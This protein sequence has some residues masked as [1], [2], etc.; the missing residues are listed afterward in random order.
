MKIESKMNKIYAGIIALMMLGIVFSSIM[1]TRTITD[2]GDTWTGTMMISGNTDFKSGSYYNL[3]KKIYNSKG[4]VY[5]AT[6]PNIQLAVND[7]NSTKGGTV[8][9]PSGTFTLTSPLRFWKYEIALEGSGAVGDYHMTNG[10]IITGSAGVTDSLV[11]LGENSTFRIEHICF[12]DGAQTGGGTRETRCLIYTYKCGDHNVIKECFF[13]GALSDAIHIN[14]SAG[15]GG[16]GTLID[17]CQFLNFGTCGIYLDSAAD[18][19][20]DH[21]DLCSTDKDC[22]FVYGSA[23]IMIRDCFTYLSRNGIVIDQ[24]GPSTGQITI[25]GCHSHDNTGAGFLFNSTSGVMTV[26]GCTSDLNKYG[27]Y[28]HGTSNDVSHITMTGC[29]SDANTVGLLMLNDYTSISSNNITIVGC[30]FADA[31]AT[32]A[33]DTGIRIADKAN[34]VTIK[35]CSFSDVTYKINVTTS[36]IRS[37]IELFNYTTNKPFIYSAGKWNALW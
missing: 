9:L 27:Y 30:L 33:T 21:C 22:I 24:T 6:G 20:I 18:M 37:N 26:S 7:L 19:W 8:W 3:S 31:A 17:H 12:S 16:A 34:N 2:T 5:N 23:N 25:S 28:F 15:V 29:T 14:E 4:H 36:C 35:G 32:S 1:A 10:T 13:N 11:I